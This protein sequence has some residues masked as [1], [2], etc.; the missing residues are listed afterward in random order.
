MSDSTPPN[1]N[2]PANAAHDADAGLRET[3]IASALM[4]QGS[5]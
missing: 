3:P 1:P 4:H 5:S 2:T